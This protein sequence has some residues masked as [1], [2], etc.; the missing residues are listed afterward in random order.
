MPGR[1]LAGDECLL[2]S[3]PT[4]YLKIVGGTAPGPSTRW[5]SFEEAQPIPPSWQGIVWRH[6][7]NHYDHP[8]H[9]HVSLELNLVLGGR[10]HY[11]VGG[12]CHPLTPGTVLFVPPGSDHYLEERSP[13]FEMWILALKPSLLERA[14]ADP[15]GHAFLD[16]I[17]GGDCGRLL[18]PDDARWL[19]REIDRF[20]D[21][22]SDDFRHAGLAYALAGAREAFSRARSTPR[23]AAIS[24]EVHRAMLLLDG[25][26]SLSRTALADAVNADPDA[27]SHVF[28]REIGTGLVAYRNRVRIRHFLELVTARRITLLDACLEA[29]FGSYP[30][31]HR[32]FVAETGQTPRDYLAS[33]PRSKERSRGSFSRSRNTER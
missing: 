32:V 33:R 26:P 18:A 14:C 2:I 3:P 7:G 25:D 24:A 6:R 30:Q 28:R 15:A 23:D 4:A 20:A 13:D 31:F 5:T 19:G 16:R 22:S 11:E 9:R 29:G 17:A 1:L 12:R 21:T 8:R 27:L 10:G